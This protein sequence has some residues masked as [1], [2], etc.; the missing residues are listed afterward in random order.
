[1]NKE[2]TDLVKSYIVTTVSD[3]NTISDEAY[4]ILTHIL[5]TDRALA[6]ELCDVYEQIESVGS[7][8]CVTGYNDEEGFE[9]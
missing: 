1:M 5:Q 9:L 6:T 7:R 2:T 4:N 8:Y 3:G